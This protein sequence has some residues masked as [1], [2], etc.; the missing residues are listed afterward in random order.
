MKAL[1]I[2]GIGSLFFCLSTACSQQERFYETGAYLL[3][4]RLAIKILPVSGRTVEKDAAHLL[5]T[6]R[7]EGAL[8]DSNSAEGIFARLEKNASYLWADESERQ[9]VLPALKTSLALARRTA[10]AFDPAL[11]SLTQLWGFSS[12]TPRQLP[13]TAEE[14]QQAR[15][16]SGYT[17]ILSFDTSGV[18]VLPR[19]RIDL[20]AIAKGILADRAATLLRSWGYRQGLLDFGGDILLLGEKINAPWRVAVRHPRQ[21]GRWWGIVHVRDLAVV[22][23]GDYERYFVFEKRRY[24][25]LLDPKTGLPARACVSVTVVGPL[26]S[27]ADAL[28]TALFVLGPERGLPLLAREF[29]DYQALFILENA[30]GEL[31]EERSPGFSS[32]TGWQPSSQQDG[33]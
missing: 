15:E 9:L 7:K 21:G 30:E 20:G 31:H 16:R 4:T 14:L 2:L 11:G 13:P 27:L 17:R 24:H 12:L 25:H 23:S 5:K 29:P 33:H 8:L 32:L 26:A 28:S 19:T 1:Q 18:R 3:G 10:G 6:I 22:T